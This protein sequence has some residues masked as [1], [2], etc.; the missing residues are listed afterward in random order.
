MS[1]RKTVNVV[2]LGC[3][4]NLVDSERVLSMLNKAGFEAYHQ[5]SDPTDIVI[6]NTCGFIGDAKEESINNILNF[7]KAK[8]DGEISELYVMGCLSERYRQDLINEI[9]EVD[10]F[11]GKFDWDTL[12]TDLGETTAADNEADD[13]NEAPHKANKANGDP[14]GSSHVTT[15]AHFAYIKISEGCNRF[16]AFCAIPLITG[17]HHSRTIEDIEQEVS[18]LAA[19]GVKEFNIIAQDLSSYGLDIYGRHALAQLIDRLADIKGVE[20]IRLHYAYPAD[21]PMDILEVM[22][23]RKNVC[24]YLDIALQH[25]SDKV[26]TNMRRH[27]TADETRRLLA[28]IR[29][30]VPGIHIRTTLMVGFPGEDEEAFEELLDFV[31]EQR[32]ERMG[33]FS[34]SEEEGTFGAKN[35]T[36]DIPEDVKQQRLNR[37]MNLQE[38]ISMEIQQEKVGKTFPVIID[39]EEEDFYVGRTQYDSPEVDPEV[40]VKKTRTL[41]PGDIVNVKIT[42][43]MPF[44]LIGIPEEK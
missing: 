14:V 43:A 31:K 37:L 27:I 25:I 6:I 7:C 17:R 22:A 44:E 29:R 32:F 26:L 18:R 11:Y 16:C 10:R 2:T 8:T 12:V 4:K 5:T 23:R 19:D 30:Q 33:A 35:F 41:I 34:Y 15:P 28:E 36:D 40:L 9:P 3:S 1:H 38:E 13:D 24:K 42:E 39:N 21:F 20:M